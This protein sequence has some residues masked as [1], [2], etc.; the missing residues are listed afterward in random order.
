MARRFDAAA[1]QQ[2][3]WAIMFPL[4]RNAHRLSDVSSSEV[5]GAE[6]IGRANGRAVMMLTHHSR[7]TEQKQ[8]DETQVTATF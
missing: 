3:L 8:W 6:E 2:C 5:R 4:L 1:W 7:N